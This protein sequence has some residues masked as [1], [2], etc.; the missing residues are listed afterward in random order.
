MF[1][2]TKTKNRYIRSNFPPIQCLAGY[3]FIFPSLAVEALCLNVTRRFGI[4]KCLKRNF[5][6]CLQIC[7]VYILD[8]RVSKFIHSKVAIVIEHCKLHVTSTYLLAIICDDKV[9]ITICNI[10]LCVSLMK[11]VTSFRKKIVCK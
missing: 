10:T 1:T 8:I 11:I 9:A 7:N 6:S 5:K 2:D 3:D 4:P